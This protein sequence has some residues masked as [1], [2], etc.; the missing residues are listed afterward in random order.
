[1]NGLSRFRLRSTQ[2]FSCLHPRADHGIKRPSFSSFWPFLAIGTASL[3]PPRYA[4]EQTTRV[5]ILAARRYRPKSMHDKR[6]CF[7]SSHARVH[8]DGSP[9]V[10]ESSRVIQSCRGFMNQSDQSPPVQDVDHLQYST[11]SLFFVLGT[12]SFD[13][14]VR[15]PPQYSDA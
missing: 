9:Q 15:P 11:V 1:V 10:S 4:A 8:K 7:G 14:W 2:P 5:L 12:R 6:R 3:L 13:C